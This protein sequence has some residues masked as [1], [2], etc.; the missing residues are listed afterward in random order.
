MVYR[1]YKGDKTMRSYL[2][3]TNG[4]SIKKDGFNFDTNMHYAKRLMKDVGL[5]DV[6]YLLYDKS[7]EKVVEIGAI[8]C[9]EYYEK[10]QMGKVI[11]EHGKQVNKVFPMEIKD[12]YTIIPLEMNDL[13][14]IGVCVS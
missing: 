12:N 7:Q 8:Q 14:K 3:I 4:E 11:F 2:F 9:I 5:Y 10:E 6:N 13:Q 1:N